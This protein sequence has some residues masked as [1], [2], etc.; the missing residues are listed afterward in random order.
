VDGGH[1]DQEGAAG[2]AHQRLD[3]PLLVGPPHPAE[4]GLE[5]V[6]ALEPQ[7]LGGELAVAAAEDLGHGDLEVVVAD[8]ARDAAEEGEGPGMPLQERLG[9]FAREGAAEEGVGVRQGHD[10]HRH[11]GGPSVERDLG[12]AEVDLGLAGRVGQRDEDLGAAQPPGG[13]G[14]LDDSQAA[15]IGVLVAEPLEDADGGVPLLPGGL[16]VTLQDLVDDAQEGVELGPGPGGRAAVAGRLGVGEDLGERVPVE[17]VLTAGG[18]LAEAVD[19]DATADLGPVL[20]V[21][22]HP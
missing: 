4:V 2:V 6:V 1:R 11:L 21:G 20:H 14:L 19:E 18:A 9:A 8:P 15:S 12:L 5:E 3:V 13:D 16:L 17:V 10:E 7:E 22:V